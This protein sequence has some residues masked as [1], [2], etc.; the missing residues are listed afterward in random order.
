MP[1]AL[2]LHH[3]APTDPVLLLIGLMMDWSLTSMLSGVRRRCQCADIRCGGGALSWRGQLA[4]AFIGQPRTQPRMRMRSNQWASSMQLGGSARGCNPA[5]PANTIV[6]RRPHHSQRS[7]SA[8]TYID[9]VQHQCLY[10][11]TEAGCC[12]CLCPVDLYLL[13][14]LTCS[15]LPARH[16]LCLCWWR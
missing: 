8:V 2:F 4:P 11:C 13:L 10:P 1:L 6:S 7:Q 5:L 14:Y 3:Q 15:L 12:C 16:S 9:V